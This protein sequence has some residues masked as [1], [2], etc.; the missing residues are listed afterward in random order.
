MRCHYYNETTVALGLERWRQLMD[1]FTQ[2]DYSVKMKIHRVMNATD[3]YVTLLRLA[4]RHGDGMTFLLDLP[5]K[6]CEGLLQRLVSYYTN[7]MS[8]NH[9]LHEINF[10]FV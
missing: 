4:S 8:C 3:A 7:I 9:D 10:S 5:T 6:D 2:N 1:G